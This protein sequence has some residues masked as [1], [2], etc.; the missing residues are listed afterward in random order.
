MQRSAVEKEPAQKRQ[1]GSISKYLWGTESAAFQ[2]KARK[3][4]ETGRRLLVF[5]LIL[6]IKVDS[7]ESKV[8]EVAATLAK[9]SQVKPIV[10]RVVQ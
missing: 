6:M 8:V 7:T 10:Q 1:K 5:R 9:F 4:R 3:M 2:K